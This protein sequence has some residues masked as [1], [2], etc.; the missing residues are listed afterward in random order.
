MKILSSISLCFSLNSKQTWCSELQTLLIDPL[1]EA[2]DWSRLLRWAQLWVIR[3]LIAPVS[4]ESD[5]ETSAGGVRCLRAAQFTADQLSQELPDSSPSFSAVFI[6][7]NNLLSTED[8]EHLVHLQE[9]DI[10]KQRRDD[11]KPQWV[12]PVSIMLTPASCCSSSGV[13]KSLLRGSAQVRIIH[14]SWLS[15]RAN[16]SRL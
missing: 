6:I 9:C 16:R 2:C 4:T 15:A 3:P 11:V 10:R 5:V 12:K 14:H 7:Q 8:E 13:R 1:K